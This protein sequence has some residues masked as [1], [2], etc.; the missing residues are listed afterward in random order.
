MQIF[1]NRKETPKREQMRFVDAVAARTR[2]EARDRKANASGPPVALAL[3]APPGT[4]KTKCIKLA[5]QYFKEVLGWTAGEEYQC[6]ASQNR[7]AA[8]IDGATIHSWGEVPIDRDNAQAR[9]KR[10]SS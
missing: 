9:E 3:L 5:C 2:A 7:M 6:I 1:S 4:G 8:R 10:A